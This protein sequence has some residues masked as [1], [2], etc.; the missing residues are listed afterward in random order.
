MTKASRKLLDEENKRRMRNGEEPLQSLRYEKLDQDKV[1]S[2]SN[3]PCYTHN[4]RGASTAHIPSCSTTVAPDATA[5]N[6]I[7]EKVVTGKIG[8]AD[9]KEVL[10]KSKCLAPAFNKGAYQF[11]GDGDAARDAGKKV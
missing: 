3:L 9:A 10:R 2:K 8:G 6:S 11:V 5:R 1:R 7:M 4:P